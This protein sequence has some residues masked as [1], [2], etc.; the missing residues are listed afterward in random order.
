MP[1]EPIYTLTKKNLSATSKAT[2]K[3]TKTTATSGAKISRKMGYFAHI[4][5]GMTA[6]GAAVLAASDMGIGEFMELQ[7]HSLFFQLRGQATLPDNIVIL[8]IDNDSIT[9]PGQYYRDNPEK[10]SYL[11]PLQSFPFPRATYAEVIEKLIQGGAR[12]VAVD[13]I[14]DRPSSYGVEDDRHLQEVLQRHHQ[15][16]TLAAIYENSETHQ[17][18]FWQLTQPQELFRNTGI[19]V[20]SVNFPLEIDGK[21]HRHAS[22][23]PKLLAKND[24]FTPPDKIP[25]L[26]EATLRASGVNYP[27]PLGD[28]LYFWG[29]AGTFET[30]PF[31][32][33]LDP[34][35]WKHYLQSGQVFKD[36]IV[37]IG[38][39]AQLSNDFHGVAVSPS[40]LNPQKMA[41]VEIH[42][43]A[44]ATLMQ[45]RSISQK[46]TNP[47]AEGLF[48]FTI[49]G[50]CTVLIARGK[51][52]I[53]R[54]SYGMVAAVLWGGVSFIC[55]TSGRFIIPA[56]IPIV[57]I[58]TIST[59]YLG[60]EIIREIFRKRH[61]VTIFQKY[62]TSPVVQEIISQ[63]DDLLDLLQQRELALSGKI[64]AGRYK[65]VKVLGSGG[66][67]ETY[68]AED[69]LLPNH[70]QCVVKQLQPVNHKAE[71]I[72]IARR[73]F[74]SEAETLQKLGNH[75][76]IP[77]LLAF[78]EEEE[79]YLIQEYIDGHPLSQELPIGKP[80]DESIVIDILRDLLQILAFVHKN[81]VIHRDI[82]PSNIIRRHGDRKL[83]LIDFG[84][85]KEVTTQLF[86][87]SEQ[88]ALT[89]GIGT[90][91]Y[92]PSE[93]CF[94]RPQYNSDIYAVGMIAIR[95]LTGIAPHDLAR[96]TDGELQWLDKA[97]VSTE[98]A[99]IL[100]RMVL[101]DF[102]KRYQTASE[103]LED[104]NQLII[105]ENKQHFWADNSLI[106]VVNL[107][108]VGL[109]TIPYL[110]IGE[111]V[112]A[113]D[114][115]TSKLPNL[116]ND[117]TERLDNQS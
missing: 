56:A 65:I 80:V 114:L 91:G 26:G 76:Q 95:A 100:C 117:S 47:W 79:F 93:Q 24:N 55:F 104:L 68:I 105:R 9:V 12:H 30:I 116:L 102:Q 62:K 3:H 39:T 17:G 54:F 99:S 40:W 59:V 37:L 31:W 52:G 87:A 1:K 25:S 84:A 27:K 38:A 73:L 36:K 50:G 48:V 110:G 63:Q 113:S 10:Y 98:L 77:Q 33:V 96:N 20:G 70:P 57:A 108:D 106:N 4:L 34:T 74:N 46:I 22:V 11:K 64:L 16:V 21:I 75:P 92:S 42:A 90:K 61:L 35:N 115:P 44:I 109:D 23:F 66:F 53:R 6:L 107:E 41:G 7:A 94:G 103:V 2:G 82:K 5:A 85:V 86:D 43:Q 8:A 78:F 81:G 72:I 49:V 32:Y 19:T 101:D 18:S 60:I 13:V 51:A 88:T 14:F 112:S 28:R 58:A 69:T 71:Q 111:E 67:S 89:I 97:I 83:V 29:G 15:K 45:G